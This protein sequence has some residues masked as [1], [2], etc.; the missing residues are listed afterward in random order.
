MRSLSFI[1]ASMALI[2][3]AS[4][5]TVGPDY[6]EPTPR[7][8]E[9]SEWNGKLEGGLS[10]EDLDPELLAKWWTSLEDP[11][12]TSLINR[13]VN[14]NLDLRTASAQLRQARAQRGIAGAAGS[15][16]IAASASASQVPTV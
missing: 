6:E 1:F 12:L 8:G 3:L 13:A 11:L 15:P 14:A 7:A 10:A 5:T 9:M 16:T 2:S 4:C